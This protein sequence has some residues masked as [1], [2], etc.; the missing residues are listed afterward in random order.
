MKSELPAGGPSRLDAEGVIAQLD[1]P[2]REKLMIRSR[3]LDQVEWMETK[4]NRAR[5]RHYALRLTTVIGGIL[6][7][8]LISFSL[9][10]SEHRWLR[11]VTFGVSLVVA[12]AAAVEEVNHYGDLWRHYRRYAETLKIEGWQYFLRTGPYRRYRT[13][14]AGLPVFTRRVEQMLLED[15]AEYF[16]RVVVNDREEARH[17]VI[18]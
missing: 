7:P 8:A 18:A 11:W 16:G 12:V 15:L 10:S 2:E 13:H 9:G 3:W 14:E 4:A 17:D 6:V 5:S 1:L